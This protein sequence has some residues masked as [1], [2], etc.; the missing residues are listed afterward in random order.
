MISM[1]LFKETEFDLFDLNRDEVSSKSVQGTKWLIWVQELSAGNV[2]IEVVYGADL[3]PANEHKL[4]AG[5]PPF[6]LPMLIQQNLVKTSLYGL[7]SSNLKRG[8]TLRDAKSVSLG[9]N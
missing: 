8:L 4:A 7:W 3:S 9:W 6:I 1:L 2:K 5:L